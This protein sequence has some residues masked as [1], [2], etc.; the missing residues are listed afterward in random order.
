MEVQVTTYVV[1]LPRGEKVH[2]PHGRRV[3]FTDKN[4]AT[5]YLGRCCNDS[6][7]ITI[8]PAFSR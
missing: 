7:L 5:R 2:A 6:K 4:E 8:P 3:R 1:Q